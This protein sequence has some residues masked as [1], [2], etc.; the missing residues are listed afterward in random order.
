MAFCDFVIKYDKD[1]D[2]PEDITRRI[3]YS[4]FIKRLKA[5]K[6]VVIFF[7]GGSGEGKSLT[8]VKLQQLLLQLQGLDIREYLNDINVYLPI[9]YPQKMRALLNEK[10][11]KK[12]NILA[13]HEARNLV[14][15]KLWHSFVTQTIGDINAMSR[16]L[17]RLCIIITSQ[18]IRDITSDIRYTL[19]YYITVRRPK[20]KRARMYVNVMWADDTDL[21]K[22]KLRKRRLSGYLVTPEGKYIRHVPEYFEV[23]MVDK[24]IVDEFE[25]GDKDAKKEIMERKIDK[26]LS[27]MRKD[28]DIESNKID[29]MVKFYTDKPEQLADIGKRFKSGWRLHKSSRD[30]FELTPSE[31]R[32]FEGKLNNSLKEMGVIDE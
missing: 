29:A 28:M 1:K 8:V 30:M 24:D 21:D 26:L 22:P 12:V 6:P 25:K 32:D 11:L 13:V 7:G 2:T 14:K 5:N 16:S 31:A 15:A 20:S 23:K 18:F 10:R 17:K 3:I 19:N 27:E 9:E 4:V